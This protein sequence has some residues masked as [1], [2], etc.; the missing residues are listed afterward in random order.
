[1]NVEFYDRVFSRIQI[2]SNV[3]IGKNICESYNA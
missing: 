3:S 1:M 2:N